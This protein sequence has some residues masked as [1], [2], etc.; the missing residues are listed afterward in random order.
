MAETYI[1]AVA[2]IRSRELSLLTE[3]VVSQLAA[4][5]SEEDCRRI[6]SE[7]GWGDPDVPSEEMLQA[8]TKKTWD[9]IRELVPDHMEIFDVFRL[10]AD[11]H[12]LKAAVKETCTEGSHPG[13]YLSG[14]TLSAELIEAAVRES[15]YEKLPQK[16]Q[17]LAREAKDRLLT[18]QDGQLCDIIIDR[19]ALEAVREAGEATK[20]ELLKDY[21]ELLCA[22]GTIKTAVRC[23]RTGKSRNFL[24]MALASCS[25]LDTA[26]LADAATAGFDAIC[27]YLEH[28]VYSGAVEELKKSLASFERWCDNRTIETIRPQIHNPFGIGPLA[29]YILARE[30]EIRTV[31]IILAAKRN[32]MPEEILR[33]RVRVMYV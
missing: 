16:L 19:A 15:D 6:L 5:E 25:T 30:N 23:S 2:R 12:N 22:T 18:T 13:I 21:G 11:Y 8:E 33:E 4:C 1:Y 20:E 9:L 7:K 10:P 24:S 29:A 26:A 27:T 17:A 14:G 28:T 3:S 32:H 31:R